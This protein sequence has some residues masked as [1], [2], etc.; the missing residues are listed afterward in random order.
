MLQ[1]PVSPQREDTENV[2][3][4]DVMASPP[5]KSGRGGHLLSPLQREFARQYVLTGGNATKAATLAGYGAPEK[6]GFRALV[7]S[8]V[9]HE[10]K[11]LTIVHVESWLPIAIRQLVDIMCDPTT[12]AKARVM[13]ANSLLDR[14]GLRPK[15]DGPAVQV[16]VQINGQQA[17][18]AIAEVWN[19]RNGRLSGQMSDIVPP[20]SDTVEH[21]PR[22]DDELDDAGDDEPDP[23]GRGGCVDQGPVPVPVAIPPHS[24]EHD[25]A[26][27][28]GIF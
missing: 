3:R 28:E 4:N 1:G 9:L 25:P 2:A 23:P 13:A 10:I 24:P 17:Q 18:A 22:D 26:N 8:T 27:P 5:P 19:A 7:N 21:E 6:A 15:S 12:D 14:G 16:N 20:M 11:R